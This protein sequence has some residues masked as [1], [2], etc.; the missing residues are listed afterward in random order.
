VLAKAKR[1]AKLRLFGEKKIPSIAGKAVSR[2]VLLSGGLQME[3]QEE[4][5]DSCANGAKD[6][7]PQNPKG[8]GPFLPEPLYVNRS[9]AFRLRKSTRPRC[10]QN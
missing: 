2:L 9:H 3:L 10:C 5:K 7:A 1:P 6:A 4:Q 8:L